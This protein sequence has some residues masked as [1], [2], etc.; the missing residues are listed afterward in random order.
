M[1]STDAR[2]APGAG[3]HISYNISYSISHL[4]AA[5]III[6]IIFLHIATD[7]TS[8]GEQTA[9]TFSAQAAALLADA[10]TPFKRRDRLTQRRAST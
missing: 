7:I 8:G 1:D 6:I 2:P 9:S 3:H 4:P 10:E 5:F